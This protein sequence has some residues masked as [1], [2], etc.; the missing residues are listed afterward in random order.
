MVYCIPDLID[1]PDSQPARICLDLERLVPTGWTSELVGARL[2][3]SG[4]ENEMKAV[5]LKSFGGADVMYLGDREDP[6]PGTGQVL[7]RVVTTSVNRPDL[8]QREGN[9]PPPKGESDVLGLEVAG[10]IAAVGEGVTQWQEGARVMGL[11]GGG[12]YAELALAW[13]S[14]LMPVPDRLSWAE[15]A[16]ICET[17][18]TAHLNLF[19]FPGLENGQSALLHGG[20]GGVNTAAIQLCRLLSPD[21]PLF[22]TASAKKT[23]RVAA[24]GAT[25]VINYQS[26]DFAEVIKDL[27]KG[28]GVDVILDHIGAPYLASNLKCLAVNGTLVLIGVM[29]GV[30]SEVNLAQLMVRRQKIVG[31][32][33]RPRSLTEKARIIARFADDVLNLFKE[34]QI[35]PL[36]D[37]VFPLEDVCK[38]HQMMESSDHFGKLVLQVDQTQ[39]VQ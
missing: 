7:I 24:L 8:I 1:P 3:T 16:C 9:Y 34:G 4:R 30:K 5:L 39:D 11:V 32:V 37:Q 31:S 35:I 12:A 18:I 10:T 2:D 14:H 13:A 28:R 20:G 21:S 29:G 19:Q 22:V 27:T 15:A 23:E 6:V 36:V 33:L 17:Y 26:Q 25:H 38:A